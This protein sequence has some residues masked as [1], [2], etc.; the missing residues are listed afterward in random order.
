MKENIGGAVVGIVPFDSFFYCCGNRRNSLFTIAKNTAVQG[1]GDYSSGGLFCCEHG[2]KFP[3]EN[4]F[5]SF[6]TPEK[7]AR[8]TGI[9][10]VVCVAEGEESGLLITKQRSGV[11]VQIYPKKDGEWQIGTGISFSQSSYAME[12]GMI[13]LYQYKPTGEHYISVI[14]FGT[15]IPIHDSVGSV[16]QTYTQ[17]EI[18][19]EHFSEYYAYIPQFDDTYT[20][21]INGTTIAL[22]EDSPHKGLF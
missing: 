5:M 4:A 9:G 14:L 22:T 1:A 8:Y 17:D 16:F 10:E 7:A 19:A 18:T 21:T 6:A 15:D 2:L 3:A 11:Q 12:K 13:T 20:V